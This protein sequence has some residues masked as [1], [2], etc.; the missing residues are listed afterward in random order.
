MTTNRGNASAR[1]IPD[2]SPANVVGSGVNAQTHSELANF[3]WD[4]CNR[5][6]GPT[7]AMSTAR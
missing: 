1:P 6:R 3:I 2:A 5:L 7:S 4:I